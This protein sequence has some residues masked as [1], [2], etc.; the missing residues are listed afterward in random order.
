MPVTIITT[1]Q[2]TLHTNAHHP[3]QAARIDAIMATLHASP[4][5]GAT[6]QVA[7]MADLDCIRTVHTPDHVAWLQL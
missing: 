4:I 3:E 1:P 7:R 2:H 5:T 6:F